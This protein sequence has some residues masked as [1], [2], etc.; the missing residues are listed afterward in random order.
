MDKSV[1]V[2]DDQIGI[3]ILLEEIIKNEGYQVNSVDNGQEALR[4][5]VSEKPDLLL[6]DFWLP[7]MNGG[8]VIK[9]M[10]QN[11]LFIP[12]ILMSGL[13]DEAK[14]KT[15]SFKSISQIIGKPFSVSQIQQLTATILAKAQTNDTMTMELIQKNS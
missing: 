14:E 4:F 3:R 2:V 6:I 9:R 15:R 7:L 12:T 10:E 11:G 8:E 1:L 13:P 5:I